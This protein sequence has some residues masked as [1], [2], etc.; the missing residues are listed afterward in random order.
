MRHDK[1]LSKAIVDASYLI[2]IQYIE[3]CANNEKETRKIIYEKN[4]NNNNTFSAE[5]TGKT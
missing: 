4:S 5:E 2:S 3:K 1:K